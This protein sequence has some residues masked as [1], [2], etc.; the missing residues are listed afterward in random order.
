MGVRDKMIKNK[1]A[2]LSSIIIFAICRS[3]YFPFPNNALFRARTTFMSFPISDNQ[4]YILLGIIGSV[5]FVIAMVLLVKGMKKYYFRTIIIALIVYAMLPTLLITIYQETIAS[6]INAISYNGNGQCRFEDAGKDLI[7]GE[8]N[9]VLYNRSNRAVTFELQFL[10]SSEDDPRFESLMNL[11]APYHI[12]I[13]ANQ[14]K[15][16]HLKKVLDVSDVPKH[17]AG[18]TSNDVHVKL[19]Y[20][21]NARI[22]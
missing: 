1:V 13:E 8:C 3:L 18:G 21:E 10:D 12:T 19:I 7:N 4:G 22:L 5:L 17:I 15:L 9:L 14:K 11:G 16:I 20:K 6:G 2:I